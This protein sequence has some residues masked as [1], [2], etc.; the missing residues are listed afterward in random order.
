MVLCLP[1]REFWGGLFC[2][3]GSFLLRDKEK[4]TSLLNKPPWGLPGGSLGGSTE[5]S[6]CGGHPGAPTAAVHWAWPQTSPPPPHVSCAR[7]L[8]GT[9][10]RFCGRADL[11]E[12]SLCDGAMLKSHCCWTSH[13]TTKSVA[14]SV[15]HALWVMCTMENWFL[16]FL[17]SLR[18]FWPIFSMFRLCWNIGRVCTYVE[19]WDKIVLCAKRGEKYL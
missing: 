16:W 13:L 7:A 9:T 15:L 19:I 12:K 1:G 6:R 17:I 18:F 8:T 4:G 2:N 3:L 14:Q 5:S 11:A 10:L